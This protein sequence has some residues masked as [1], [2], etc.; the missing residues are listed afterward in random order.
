MDVDEV[1]PKRIRDF[2]WLT[3]LD[4]ETQEESFQRQCD[5]D[6][7]TLY[8]YEP[9]KSMTDDEIKSLSSDILNVQRKRR[10]VV[11]ILFLNEEICQANYK[12]LSVMKGFKIRPHLHE[13]K[14]KLSYVYDGDVK[15][16]SLKLIVLNL[17]S[18][19]T[20]GQLKEIW[21]HSTCIFQDPE[22]PH[23]AFVYFYSP[24]IA[25]KAFDD[26]KEKMIK[27]SKITILYAKSVKVDA[28]PSASL[29]RRKATQ[30]WI[31]K[32]K[33]NEKKKKGTVKKD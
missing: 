11:A 8:I 25:R 23:R 24:E 13:R 19:T 26:G 3:T 9:L 30:R 1:K 33:Y 18:K 7:R 31:A 22:K 14:P 15:V 12:K 29:M 4:K 32:K 28:G 10:D 27:G 20:R 2:K 21:P 16:N 17:P 5:Q 6:N